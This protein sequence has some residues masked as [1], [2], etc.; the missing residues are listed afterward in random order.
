MWKFFLLLVMEVVSMEPVREENQKKKYYIILPA[1]CMA[2]LGK[3]YFT[4]KF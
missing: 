2:K 3:T 4:D 1:G